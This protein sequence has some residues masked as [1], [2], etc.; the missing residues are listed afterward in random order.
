MLYG[1]KAPKSAIEAASPSI[2]ELNAIDK[3]LEGDAD[4]L[5]TWARDLCFDLE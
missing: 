5:F 4:E 3:E 2:D 1:L